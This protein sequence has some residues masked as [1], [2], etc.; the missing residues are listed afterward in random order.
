MIIP[1]F[2]KKIATFAVISSCV[3]SISLYAS[4]Q[5]I[6]AIINGALLTVG[7]EAIWAVNPKNPTQKILLVPSF[8][9]MGTRFVKEPLLKAVRSSGVLVIEALEMMEQSS[10]DDAKIIKDQLPSLA[11]LKKNGL[12]KP[13]PFLYGSSGW[14]QRINLEALE[15]LRNNLEPTF[16]PLLDEY[17]KTHKDRFPPILNKFPIDNVHPAMVTKLLTLMTNL[18]TKNLGMDRQIARSFE[19]ADKP[20]LG[21]ET[22][23]ELGGR[24]LHSESALMYL[25]IFPVE[26]DDLYSDIN[27]LVNQIKAVDQAVP[28]QRA[29]EIQQQLNQIQMFLESPKESLSERQQR[30]LKNLIIRNKKWI[31]RLL[32]HLEKYKDKSVVVVTGALH[33]SGKEGLLQLLREQGFQFE[34]FQ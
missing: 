25:S 8:H 1:K 6:E 20:V 31:P 16:S 18:K 26:Y 23:A 28:A 27:L 3:S 32:E 4:P 17:R 14:S 30:T 21:L 34:Y 5:R 33:Y 22:A 12:V 11:L 2:C 29:Q 19:L 13:E 10:W 24:Q 7:Q 15:Y 9:Y